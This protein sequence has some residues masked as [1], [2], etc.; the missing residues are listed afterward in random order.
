MVFSIHGA[1]FMSVWSGEWVLE[2]VVRRRFRLS[3]WQLRLAVE[4]G[5]VRGRWVVDLSKPGLRSLVVNVRDVEGHLE[6]IRRFPRGDRP[7]KCDVLGFFCPRCGKFVAPLACSQLARSYERGLLSLVEARRAF[8]VSHYRHV[9]TEYEGRLLDFLDEGEKA[10]YL[11]LLERLRG[12]DDPLVRAEL[13][14]LEL[15]AHDRAKRFYTE[16]AVKMLVED[17]LLSGGEDG[18]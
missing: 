13:E 10:R 16:K 3:S 1:T 2:S 14:G 6:E 11:E 9:H 15:V 5:V 8:M 17:G 18:S 12:S 4:R 7:E